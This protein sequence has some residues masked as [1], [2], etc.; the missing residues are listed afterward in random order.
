MIAADGSALPK[1]EP[2]QTTTDL[3]PTGREI[4]RVPKQSDRADTPELG[5]V[6]ISSTPA[7][8]EVMVPRKVSIA[9]SA[10]ARQE[11]AGARSDLLEALKDVKDRSSSPLSRQRQ[12]PDFQFVGSLAPSPAPQ[13]RLNPHPAKRGLGPTAPLY[14]SLQARSKIDVVCR[15]PTSSAKEAWSREGSFPG[16]GPATP[17]SELTGWDLN[18]SASSPILSPWISGPGETYP[19]YNAAEMSALRS[20]PQLKAGPKPAHHDLRAWRTSIGSDE[21]CGEEEEE[22]LTHGNDNPVSDKPARSGSAMPVVRPTC[23]STDACLV[24]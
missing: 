2:R 19:G 16:R 1:T 5:A 13:P 24:L 11:L 21:G 17:R 15:D 20:P 18:R 6:T 10:S 22:D 3:R 23:M 7:P 12:S 8:R 9:Q 14:S 4:V